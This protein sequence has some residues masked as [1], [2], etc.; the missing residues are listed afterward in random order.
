MPNK[1]PK[2]AST[3]SYLAGKQITIKQYEFNT[4]Y[5]FNSNGFRERDFREYDINKSKTRILVLGD[6]FAEGWGVDQKD[7]FSDLLTKQLNNTYNKK[8]E[9]MNLGQTATGPIA[10]FANLMDF[11]LA[12]QPDIV[13]F[14]LFTGNDFMLGRESGI[15]TPWR[16]INYNRETF[17]EPAYDIF[18]SKIG[19]PLIGSLFYE[20]TNKQKILVRKSYNGYWQEFFKRPVDRELFMSLSNISSNQLETSLTQLDPKFVNLSLSGQLNPGTLTIALN[21]LSTKSKIEST[22]Y[23]IDDYKNVIY[24]IQESKRIAEA[25]GATFIVL[26]IPD[27]YDIEKKDFSIYLEKTLKYPTLPKR[28]N[29]ALYLKE[30]IIQEMTQKKII[31]IDMTQQFMAH[32]ES[33]YYLYDNHINSDGHKL[34]ANELHKTI[35]NMRK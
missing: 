28:L 4:Q 31:T 18:L 12:F 24:I 15:P 34:I 22:Y 19:L 8:V 14:T 29:E 20:V 27:I 35:L 2:V 16:H 32:K 13:I 3:G 6:S 23:N 30:K 21:N 11:G 7:R 5:K 17:S 26:V 10:Y 33:V 1:L 25:H 9:S